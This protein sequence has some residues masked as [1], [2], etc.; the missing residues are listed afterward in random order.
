MANPRVYTDKQKQQI[1]E[2]S[3]RWKANNLE[4]DRSDGRRRARIKYGMDPD[5]AEQIWNTVK[6][7][8]I[9]GTSDETKKMVIDHNHK[10]NK[11]RGKLCFSCNQGIGLFKDDPELLRLAIKYLEGIN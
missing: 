3:R 4:K 8:Q 2:A 5:E 1:R 10:T 11:I 9:C 7:C 6:Q